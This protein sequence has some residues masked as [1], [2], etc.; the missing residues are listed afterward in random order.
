METHSY[1]VEPLQL[2]DVDWFI[3]VAAVQMLEEELKR[4]NL[5]NINH[6]YQLTKIVIEQG[7]AFVV[8]KNGKLIGAIAGII[9]PNLYNPE[10]TECTELFW[11]VLPEF[12]SG[13]AGLLLIDALLERTKDVDSVMFSLLPSSNIKNKTLEK[14]GLFL[15]EYGFIKFRGT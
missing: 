14:R 6:L 13:R 5:I 10:H 1:K 15:R 4:P 8:R 11:F 9:A 12:R 2:E 7:T 3:N